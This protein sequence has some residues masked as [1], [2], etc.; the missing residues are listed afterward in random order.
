MF[1]LIH[2]KPGYDDQMVGVFDTMQRAQ[3]EAR[4]TVDAFVADDKITSMH[5]MHVYRMELNKN[6]VILK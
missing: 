5:N 3:E 2:K 4:L 1:V 6:A